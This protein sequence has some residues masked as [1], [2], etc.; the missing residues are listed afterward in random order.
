M[1]RR[2]RWILKF[3]TFVTP[4]GEWETTS[5]RRRSWAGA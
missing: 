2:R 1:K 4:A 3:W 5:G